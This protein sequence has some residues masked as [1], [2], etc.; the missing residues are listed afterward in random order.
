MR[1]Q[2]RIADSCIGGERL[3]LNITRKLE[4]LYSDCP[5]EICKAVKP[6]MEA[7][8]YLI[9]GWVEE[10]SIEYDADTTSFM[11]TKSSFQYRRAIIVIGSAFLTQTDEERRATVFHELMHVLTAPVWNLM[12]DL[13]KQIPESSRE[14]ALSQAEQTIEGAVEDLSR[15][16]LRISG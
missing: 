16:T 11:L 5:R 10:L 4:V 7:A 13:V 1:E 3:I 15:A 12:T 2:G 8:A 6:H 9:P 14:F